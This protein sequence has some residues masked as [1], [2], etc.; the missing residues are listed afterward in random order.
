V[1]YINYTNAV[2]KNLVRSDKESFSIKVDE[3]SMLSPN[4]LGRDSVSLRSRQSYGPGAMIMDI[5][6]IPDNGCGARPRAYLMDNDN[7]Q[8]LPLDLYA[9]QNHMGML[10]T[11]NCT[12]SN[13]FGCNSNKFQAC[14]VRFGTNTEPAVGFLNELDGLVMTVQWREDEVNMWI[15]S[16]KEIRQMLSNGAEDSAKAPIFGKTFDTKVL[17]TPWVDLNRTTSLCGTYRTPIFPKDMKIVSMSNFPC[18][19]SAD[20]S[21]RA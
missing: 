7:R 6:H 16:R 18:S 21:K 5:D 19:F 10:T 13:M 14:F 1:H 4:A 15:N 8:I 11:S 9:R 3:T 20:Q 12:G 2:L 17:N